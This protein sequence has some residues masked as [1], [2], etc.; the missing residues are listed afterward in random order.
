MNWFPDFYHRLTPL[1]FMIS[2]V[3]VTILVFQLGQT[4]IALGQSPPAAQ[5]TITTIKWSPAGDRIATGHSDG[6]ITIWDAASL[7]VIYTLSDSTSEV[8]SL[9]WKPDGTQL[10]SGGLDFGYEA[11]DGTA[12]VWDISSG[13]LVAELPGISSNAI[14]AVTWTP[15][16]TQIITIGFDTS[17]NFKRWDATSFELLGT[18]N[19]LGD[20]D[21]IVWSPDQ[22]RA[23]IAN[24]AA[25]AIIA[26]AVTFDVL[27]IYREPELPGGGW[28]GI[29][30]VT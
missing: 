13:S 19:K 2:V 11:F 9:G 23:A 8:N 22:T 30:Q 17:I 10:I 20:A 5:T 24:V 4:S 12:R 29:Y 1:K 21:Q 15:D 16:S 6:T 7:E 28:P 18:E 26:D 25:E 3:V 14:L 27:G